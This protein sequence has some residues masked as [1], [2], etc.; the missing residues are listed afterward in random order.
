MSNTHNAI[1]GKPWAL[2]SKVKV[3]DILIADEDFTCLV[4]GQECEVKL[5]GDTPQDD[6]S[7]LYVSCSI[8]EHFLSS[9]VANGDHIIG[10][11]V[12]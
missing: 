1:T 4:K 8:G 6:G 10:F 3:G 2:L 12:K 9:Q 11:T 5:Y 7:L